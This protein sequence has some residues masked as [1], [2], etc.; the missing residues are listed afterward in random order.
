VGSADASTDPGLIRFIAVAKPGVPVDD[1]QSLLVAT[2]EDLGVNGPAEAEVR[3]AQA[4][5]ARQREQAFNSTETFALLLS[6]SI[7]QGDWRLFFYMNDRLAQVT[8]ADVKA[9]AARYLRRDNRT[10]GL[11]IPTDAPERAHIAAAPPAD[12][13]LATFK[14]R[15]AATVAGTFDPTPANIDAHTRVVTLASGLKVALL[16]KPARGHEV[17]VRLNLGYGDLASLR[18]RAATMALMGPMLS[19]GTTR[20]T[21]QEISDRMD[22]LKVSG[23]FGGGVNTLRTTRESLPDALALMAHVLREASFPAT[24]LEQLRSQV[25]TGLEAR[26]TD[27]SALVGE[28]LAR[29]A[30]V[31]E[32]DD[33]RYVPSTAELIERVRAVRR[34]DLVALH[35]ELLGASYGELAIV[36][37]FDP[38]AIA[39]V[40]ERELGTWRSPH[41]YTRIDSIYRDVK[42][43]DDTI[44]VPDKASATLAAQL[45]L[46][47]RD[48][49]PAHPE[50]PALVLANYALGGGAGFSSR[51]VA[52]IRGKEGLSYGVSTTLANNSL[53]EV[54]VFGATATA[55][56]ANM[57]RLEQAFREELARLVQDG[58]TAQELADAKKGL[59]QQRLQGRASDA[60]L[61]AMWA[62]KLHRGKTFAETAEYD[63]KLE[64]VSREDIL[65]AV[66]MHIDPARVSVVKAGSL[67]Q[68]AK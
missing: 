12:A 40:L 22:Q 7:A 63:R 17:H 64:A 59:A 21:R 4:A 35:R 32:P 6:S 46:R 48:D 43:I 11:F 60:A 13:L 54:A 30:N 62:D 23:N 20:M 50:Y 28:R 31:F 68:A 19:R 29:N 33:P 66:R 53:D 1:V 27:L 16:P 2:A 57:P 51:L 34:E 44:V 37:D 52:R 42:P 18:G 45:L 56:P 9:A 65:S 38:D 26:R 24:E 15:D 67:A 10:V 39:P 3:R 25:L 36:G 61:A 41:A 14:G 8:A 5:I 49:D 55:A 47:T 58:L